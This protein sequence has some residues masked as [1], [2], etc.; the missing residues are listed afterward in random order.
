MF[1]RKL[2]KRPVVAAVLAAC[3]FT[4]TAQAAEIGQAA[5]DFRVVDTAG[6]YHTLSDF[7]GQTV[8][9][10]W[11][12]HD[13]PF[14]VKHYAT[15]NMQSL[16]QEMT[17]EDVAWLTVISSYP[18]TQGHVSPEQADE[19]TRSRGAAPTA[20]LLDEQGDMGRAYSARVTPHMYVI[21]GD[22]VLRYAGGIDS[23]ASANHADVER[24]DPYF[25]NAARAVLA[26]EEVERS[27]T[28]PYGCTIKYS[29][30]D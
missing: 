17:A 22:G 2:I 3:A 11:T 29:D 15:N 10:E 6:N 21:D 18:G 9:L 16:Q 27:V 28:R 24:A 8:V 14:V 19:L 20:V 4:L 26:G 13:C 23:I 25:A 30:A 5:P 1:T 12:N 7:S